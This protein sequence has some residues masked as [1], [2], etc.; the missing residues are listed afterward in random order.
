MLFYVDYI[1]IDRSKKINWIFFF[2]F[3]L[4]ECL[5]KKKLII[6]YL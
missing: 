4:V 1:D 2:F 5:L 6:M 3:I